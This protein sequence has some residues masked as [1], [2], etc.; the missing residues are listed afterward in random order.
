M[1]W[2]LSPSGHV[3]WNAEP[4]SGLCSAMELTQAAWNLRAW[5][6]YLRRSALVPLCTD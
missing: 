6:E 3:H 1:A 5:G 4:K 2:Y